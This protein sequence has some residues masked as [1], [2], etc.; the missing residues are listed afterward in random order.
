V[1]KLTGHIIILHSPFGASASW[2][3][4]TLANGVR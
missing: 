2:I 4:A 3:N 1:M